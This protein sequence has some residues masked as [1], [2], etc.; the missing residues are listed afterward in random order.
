VTAKSGSFAQTNLPQAVT[1]N[2]FNADNEMT[3]FN[4]TALS[5][6]LNGNLTGDGTNTYSWDARN[7]LASI[8]GGTTASFVFDAFGRRMNKDINGLITQFEYDGFN[9]V[10]E[11]DGAI[12]A[13]VTANL[14]TGL[15][16]DEYFARTD[17]NGA[18]NFLSDALGSTLALTDSSG[19]INTSYT[20][21]PFGNTTIGG[22]KP[23]PYQF[24]GRENDGTGLYFYRARYYSP[25]F[26]RF[27]AQDPWDFIGGGPNL[28]EY[29]AGDPVDL[30]DPSGNEVVVAIVILRA[31]VGGA[32][33]ASA[34]VSS[35]YL[36]GGCSWQGALAAGTAG[37]LGGAG[38]SFLPGG[39]VAI[40]AA[41]GALGP[42]AGEWAN[43]SS[44]NPWAIGGGLVGG[45]VAGGLGGLAAGALEADVA[46]SAL[47][48]IVKFPYASLGAPLGAAAGGGSAGCGCQH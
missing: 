4:G 28:Y 38:A 45:T 34:A 43:G 37:F 47:T 40:G 2:A 15:N 31:A 7:H 33:G 26:Q 36:S 18:M 25:T 11:L 30:R 17:S 20:Y 35:Y 32:F 27:I 13:N 39:A 12:P 10:Q 8:S 24:T 29:A 19:A 5:Y 14:L 41:A 21:E 3:G 46:G 48:G 23:N 22:S 42:A 1:G 9:P 44:L 6:D 16:I